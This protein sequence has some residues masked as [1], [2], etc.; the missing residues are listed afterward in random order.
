[1]KP[2]CRRAATAILALAMVPLSGCIFTTRKLPKPLVP[3]VVQI[4]TPEQLVDHM[5][6][7]WDA[8]KSIRADVQIRFTQM[9]TQE[10]VAK[11]WTTFPAIILMRKPEDLRVVG[12]WPVLH[13]RMFDMVSNGADFTLYVPSK[14]VAYEGPNALTHKS[15]NTI[16]NMRPGFF[17]DSLMVRGMSPDDEYMVRA[18]SDTVV[19][20]K[21]KHLLLIPEYILS[22]M[23]HKAG[24][25]ELQPIRVITFHREDLLPYQQD[26]YDDQGNL[27]TQVNYGRYV[28][29]GD[30]LF[31]STVTIK[32]PLEGFEAVLTV[33]RVTENLPLKDDQFQVQ[34]PSDTRVQHLK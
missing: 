20:V 3:E 11:D 9:K 23:R 10:G 8:L 24:S 25:R 27:Q 5:N 32:R 30:N 15:P 22:I 14:D 13:T 17:L 21:K 33:Q 16:E 1:M 7:R 28:E 2:G 29:Y 26:L 19:D 34:I 31:P 18:D 6:Q 12:F 4:A